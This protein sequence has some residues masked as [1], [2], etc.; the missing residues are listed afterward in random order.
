MVGFTSSDIQVSLRRYTARPFKQSLTQNN[1][2][3][4]EK[5]RVNK[6]YCIY[7]TW[8]MRAIKYRIICP[9][10]FDQKLDYNHYIPAIKR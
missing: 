2:I 6:Y 3:Q 9:G 8:E 5:L 7:P 10:S 1:E 4:W